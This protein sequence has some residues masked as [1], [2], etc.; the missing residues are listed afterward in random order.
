MYIP[1]YFSVRFLVYEFKTHNIPEV[2]Y[3]IIVFRYIQISDLMLT[4]IR[5]Y[6]AINCGVWT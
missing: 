1:D 3:K 2:E 5:K 6:Y 4:I